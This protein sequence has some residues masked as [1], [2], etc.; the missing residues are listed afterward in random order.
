MKLSNSHLCL[1]KMYFL[2]INVFTYCLSKTHVIIQIWDWNSQNLLN[3]IL[4]LG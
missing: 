4:L 3:I 1:N 2:A